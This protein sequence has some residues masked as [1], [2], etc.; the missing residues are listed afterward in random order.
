[1][2]MVTEGNFLTKLKEKGGSCGNKTLREELGW[3]ESDY[4][5]IKD[6]LRV[7]GTITLGRGRGGS[8]SLSG[9]SSNVPAPKKEEVLPEESGDLEPTVSGEYSDHPVGKKVNV[10][11]Y[12]T[13]EQA[14]D[15]ASRF[16]SYGRT[17]YIHCVYYVSGLPQD[18]NGKQVAKYVNSEEM[19]PES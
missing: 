16:S 8:V 12:L 14:Q 5:K 3:S 17:A 18:G 13:W 6:K 7:S 9:N 1:M 19:D 11:R 15:Y 2:S 10:N 4:E